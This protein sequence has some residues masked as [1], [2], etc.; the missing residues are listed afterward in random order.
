[1]TIYDNQI[2]TRKIP[3]LEN[4]MVIYVSGPDSGG[5]DMYVE[6]N[7]DAIQAQ[8][9]RSGFKFVYIPDLLESLGETVL[10][11]LFP[12]MEHP[13]RESI[14]EHIRMTARLGNKAGLLYR[15]GQSVFFRVLDADSVQEKI[16]GLAEELQSQNRIRFRMAPAEP[17][18]EA[19]AEPCEKRVHWSRKKIGKAAEELFDTTMGGLFEAS[20]SYE[21]KEEVVDERTQ[22]ILDEI[23]SITS[24]FGISVDDLILLLNYRVKLSRLQI[25]KS[26]RIKLADLN[27]EIELDQRA[28]AFYFLFLRHPEGIR[29][30]DMVDYRDE[31]MDI[32]WHLVDRERADVEKTID[33]LINPLGN[34]MNVCASRIKAAFIKVIGEHVAKFYCLEGPAGDKKRVPLDRDLVIWEY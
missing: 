23:D 13:S 21:T 29:Y 3:F 10:D 24:R 27:K 28:T 14:Y 18:P 7:K 33:N 19:D 2:V 32:Y 4:G 30:K 8:F 26:G 34:E 20:P 16:S 1:M 22:A 31:L 11:Y 15:R 17:E 25:F 5:Q 6:Q 12:L 9:S